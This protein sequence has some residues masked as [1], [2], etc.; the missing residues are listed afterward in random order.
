MKAWTVGAMILATI[1]SAAGQDGSA[2]IEVRSDTYVLWIYKEPLR[3]ALYGRYGQELT[4]GVRFPSGASSLWYR[5]A[6]G[7]H[8]LTDIESKKELRGKM[9][10]T[11]GTSESGRR[12]TVRLEATQ[13]NSLRVEV[14]LEPSTGILEVGDMFVVHPGERFYGL[15]TRF[16]AQT[17]P[18]VGGMRLAPRFD[19]RGERFAATEAS[20]SAEGSI[21]YPLLTSNR[22]YCI[23]VD[24][25]EAGR[26]D[27]AAGESNRLIFALRGNSLCYELFAGDN[28]FEVA[29]NYAQVVG[30]SWVPPSWA[31]GPLRRMSSGTS[32]DGLRDD[33]EFLRRQNVVCSAYLV[34]RI[35]RAEG[36]KT[37]TAALGESETRIVMTWPSGVPSGAE[38]P[39]EK[40]LVP[41]S[42]DT[43]DVT[44][45]GLAKWLRKSLKPWLDE[46][47]G[48]I[49]LEPGAGLGAVRP[50]VEL[51]DGRLAG[52][53]GRQSIT[54]QTKAI[55]GAL[56][57]P[58]DEKRLLLGSEAYS[59]T[60]AHA[61]ILPRE[62]IRNFEG[63]RAS[64][65]AMQRSALLGAPLSGVVIG[66]PEP[67]AAARDF[68]VR[69]L[70]LGTFLPLCAVSLEPDPNSGLSSVSIESA[71]V[72]RRSLRAWAGTRRALV[73]YLHASAGVAAES[74]Q[75]LL[76]PPLMAGTEDPRV[77]DR[78]DEFLLGNA[79][80]VAPVLTAS[81]SVRDVYLPQGVWRPLWALAERVEGGAVYQLE[82][83]L[84]RIPVFI[85]EGSI[86][87]LALPGLEAE[88]GSGAA[89]LD[90]VVA[91]GL[92]P[93]ADSPEFAR[94]LVTLWVLPD[95][96]G[97]AEGRLLSTSG[98]GRGRDG[99]KLITVEAVT[100]EGQMTLSL[101]SSGTA[102]AVRVEL[103]ESPKEVLS[104]TSVL[105]MLR[106]GELAQWEEGW[107][108]DT[109]TKCLYAKA[110]AKCRSITI[111]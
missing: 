3:L 14:G 6:T 18:G 98:S 107:F 97:K 1:L 86:V 30:R 104:G 67:G 74:G 96:E 31:F 61:A 38:P 101:S 53:I 72:L 88:G 62:P 26:W 52:D 59:G 64:L 27:L 105:P 93:L 24:A 83:P 35:S 56:N 87:P 82:T 19:L 7:T 39:S 55:Q 46:G 17:E 8:Q 89:N 13:H 48:G 29:R 84:E 92:G 77:G 58:R 11:C 71:P 5:T 73:P 108:Y 47:L 100:E 94:G 22:N 49:W 91:E 95:S 106:R 9:I 102:L 99:Q 54:L 16:R 69:A 66:T 36:L 50:D 45:E 79:F 65:I 2:W 60:G 109:S 21:S 85:R 110:S 78:W 111:R 43:L 33:I 103:L 28:L 15:D 75:P 68:A 4:S 20:R 44:S 76:A 40:L 41:G 12:A 80:L 81:A 23:W 25:P 90:P 51:H 37:V 42:T 63:M 57:M 10:L 34:P 32:L 70:Q